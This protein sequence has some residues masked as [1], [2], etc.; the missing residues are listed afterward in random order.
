MMITINT[1][2]W[3]GQ[4]WVSNR[5][6][7]QYSVTDA[8][9]FQANVCLKISGTNYPVTGCHIL[10]RQRPYLHHCKKIKTCTII[11]VLNWSSQC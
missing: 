3:L 5:L 6:A 7:L 9:Q 1:Q 8:W 10:H 11:F 4:L 2:I